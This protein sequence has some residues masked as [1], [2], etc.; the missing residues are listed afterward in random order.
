[1]NLILT[2]CILVVDALIIIINVIDN[3]SLNPEQDSV[4]LCANARG[5]GLNASIVV[6][7]MGRLG[8]SV[9]VKQSIKESGIFEFKP[10]LPQL[11]KNCSYAT[12]CPWKKG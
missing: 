10:S 3:P 5:K 7:T 1:M 11:L 2:K 8:S 4:S 9:M 12:T 6:P